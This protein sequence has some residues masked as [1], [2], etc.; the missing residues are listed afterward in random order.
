MVERLLRM[1]EVPGSVDT[2]ILQ[3][4]GRNISAAHGNIYVLFSLVCYCLST[5]PFP[6]ICL[7]LLS[8]T[9]VETPVRMQKIT[10]GTYETMK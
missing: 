6:L 8:L 2:R 4:H 3:G 1:R 7:L 10:H 9:R 5:S